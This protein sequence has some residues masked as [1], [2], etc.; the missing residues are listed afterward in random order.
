MLFFLLAMIPIG[1]WLAQRAQEVRGQA[2]ESTSGLPSSISSGCCDSDGQCQGWFGLASTCSQGNGACASAKQCKGGQTPCGETCKA[3]DCGRKICGGIISCDGGCVATPGR[4]TGTTGKVRKNCN[5]NGVC[6]S[7]N[8][9][10]ATTCAEDCRPVSAGKSTTG[11]SAKENPLVEWWNTRIVPEYLSVRAGISGI[12]QE[13]EKQSCAN[14]LLTELSRGA[15]YC[16][17]FTCNPGTKLYEYAGTR[18]CN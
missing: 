13:R 7:R 11:G 8:G 17:Y 5:A 15:K 16:L 10:T 18:L 1:V 2:Y 14:D 4:S 3:T 9:E 12:I 6:E